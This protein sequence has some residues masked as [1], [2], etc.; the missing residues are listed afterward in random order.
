MRRPVK[1]FVILIPLL[2]LVSASFADTAAA[3]QTDAWR[4]SAAIYGW[5]PSINGDLVYPVTGTGESL[6]LDSSTILDNLKMT[7][8]AGLQARKNKWSILADVIYMDLG[9]QKSATA[10]LPRDNSLTAEFDVGMKSWI[11][12]FDGAYTMTKSDRNETQ[13]LFGVR[14][15]W[16]ESSLGISTDS[17][18][19]AGQNLALSADVWDAVIGLRGVLA[20]GGNWA[21]PYRL[22]VGAG[23]SDFT[24]QGMAGIDYGWSW[25]G[26][27]LL[28][29]YLYYD[30]GEDSV[31][32]NMDMPGPLLGIRFKL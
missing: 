2:F 23:G 11:V 20:L 19:L 22:D 10:T 12:D 16:L 26:A 30:L 6:T 25:G 3:P 1:V 24:W 7:A 32:Q 8:Q 21:V 31:M 17:A 5:L 9:N 27:V 18:Q 14:Y 28:Y 15:L 13:F 4:Y 29:R